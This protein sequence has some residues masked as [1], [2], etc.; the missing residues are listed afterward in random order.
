MSLLL[1]TN[2]CCIIKDQMYR[3]SLCGDA[4]NHASNHRLI[5][6][7][8]HTLLAYNAKNYSECTRMRKNLNGIVH[9][10]RDNFFVIAVVHVVTL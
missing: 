2:A 1:S 3:Q 7:C 5:T 4:L 8:I 6:M 10:D 9:V